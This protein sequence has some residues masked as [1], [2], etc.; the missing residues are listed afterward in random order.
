MMDVWLDSSVVSKSNNFYTLFGFRNNLVKSETE[1]WA[2]QT[3][4]G[5]AVTKEAFAQKRTFFIIVSEK[6][7]F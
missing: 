7:R 6:K 1:I 4:K 2:S 5:N 3:F